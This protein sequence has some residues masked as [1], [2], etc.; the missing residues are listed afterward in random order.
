MDDHGW[1][2]RMVEQLREQVGNLLAAAQLL[3]PAIREQKEQKYDQYLAILNQGLYRLLRLTE[4]SDLYL[5]GGAPRRKE[6]VETQ[7]L[8]RSLG[9][10]VEGAAAT[11]GVQFQWECQ[12][13]ETTVEADR[14]LL[15]RLLLLLLKD[16]LRAAGRGGRVGLRA[17]GDGNR[18]RITVWDDGERETACGQE[19][20]EGPEAS[21]L[22]RAGGRPETALARAIAAANGGTLVFEQGEERGV[23]AVLSLSAAPEREA[24]RTPQMGYDAT[25]G[26]QTLLVEL[27]DLLPYQAYG[28]EE[29][30]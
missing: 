14:A 10:Q 21:L 13:R 8:C 22:R 29:L 17:V 12:G 7:A 15:E 26:F 28:P 16:A 1:E 18:V 2:E 3:T 27:S 6:L 19:D 9:S 4:H 24:L 11:L 5:R 25:G 20:G 23:R 30:E